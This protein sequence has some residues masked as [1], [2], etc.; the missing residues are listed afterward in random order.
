MHLVLWGAAKTPKQLNT[1]GSKELWGAAKTQSQLITLNGAAK[2]PT[3]CAAVQLQLVLYLPRYNTAPQ[4][5]I[6][7]SI[8]ASAQE[9]KVH[10]K[11][12]AWTVKRLQLYRWQS[13]LR[14]H[15][16]ICNTNLAILML[17]PDS[18]PI[19]FYKVINKCWVIYKVPFIVLL[20]HC[21]KH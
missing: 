3:P 8:A 6:S 15:I 11:E 18:L 5:N 21:I 19:T 14:R 10:A 9:K 2:N 7:P 4:P 13:V 17:I 16:T 20:I 1:I 12:L